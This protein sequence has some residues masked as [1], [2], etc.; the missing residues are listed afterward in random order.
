MRPTIVPTIKQN[1][2][3]EILKDLVTIF[4]IFGGGA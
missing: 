2:A 4:L 3:W 1:R